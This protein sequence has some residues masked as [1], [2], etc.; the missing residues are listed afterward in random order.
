MGAAGQQPALGGR[1][2]VRS[3][4]PHRARDRQAGE[5]LERLHHVDLV[6]GQ[7]EPIAEVGHSHH[8][9]RPWRRG[10][11]QPDRILPVSY[12]QW[13]DLAARGVG[14]DGR[15]DLEHV[16]AEGQLLAGTEV[17]GVVLHERCPA[18]LGRGH[19][20]QHSQ[21]RRRLPVA[22][23]A[24]AVAVGHQSL[25]GQPGQLPQSAEV[26]EVGGERGEAAAV[27]EVPQADLDPRCVPQRL[28]PVAAGSQLR[29]DLIGLVVLGDERVDLLV[30][31]CVHGRHKIG[32]AVGVDREAEPQLGV[33]LVAF[34]DGDVAHV[35]AEAGHPQRPGGAPAGRGPRPGPDPVRPPRDRSRDP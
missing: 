33:D 34:G 28:V 23:P 21:Q 8:E 22:L 7:A 18:G 6:G 1:G 4:P 19:D 31:G 32:H 17:V 5:R 10:E 25:H 20:L 35:V 15:A 3:R 26:L 29:D 14:G 11:H 16:G 27:E 13:V 9:R 24:E 12:G 30:R 2:Q